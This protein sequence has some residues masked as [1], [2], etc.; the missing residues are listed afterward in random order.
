M[1]LE[2]ET[3][4]YILSTLEVHIPKMEKNG[5][6]GKMTFRMDSLLDIIELNKLIKKNKEHG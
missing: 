4:S 2:P 3:V 1:N 5:A 6:I